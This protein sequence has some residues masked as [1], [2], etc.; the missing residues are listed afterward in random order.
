MTER[1]SFDEH[2]IFRYF[3]QINDVPRGSNHEAQ[4]SDMLYNLAL[5]KGY[6]TQRDHQG[7]ILITRPAAPGFEQAP[8]IIIQGHMDM[9]CEKDPDSDHDFL[10]DP[11]EMVEKNRWI[12]ANKTTLGA[13]DGI[14][15]A[16][17]FALLEEPDPM[18]QL[19]VLIT[20]TEETG[21]D[22]AMA[23]TPEYLDGDMLINIDSE[24]E[25]FVTVGCA[26]GATG[27]VHLPIERET[28]SAEDLRS[29]KLVISGMRGGHSGMEIAEVSKS[30][31]KLMTDY[32]RKINVSVSIKLHSFRSGSKHNA[33]PNHAEAIIS[34]SA[35]DALKVLDAVKAL[36]ESVRS[37]LLKLEPSISLTY[38]SVDVQTSV[39]TDSS[40]MRLL[41]CLELMPHG[42]YRMNPDG[43]SVETSDN[44]AVVDLGERSA[45]MV[46][47]VRSSNTARLAELQNKIGDV[48]AMF[49]G[50]SEFKDGYPAW[51]YRETSELRRLFESTFR[52]MYGKDVEVLIIHAGL[53][54]GLFAKKNPKLDMISFGP[55]ILGAHTSKERLSIDSTYRSY[56]LLKALIRRIGKLRVN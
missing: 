24:E 12:H 41:N 37:S 20:T 9:V 43:Q 53:E 48:A 21:M 16:M 44:L 6:D 26:G 1:F 52:D 11:I 32:L 23:V 14:G 45:E 54:C 34:Y 40:M 7:N 4:I 8:R 25:G 49:E 22:G 38:E 10:K 39:L 56:D 36:C 33:I 30:A 15:V 27:Y 42:V 46:L 31:L 51:E 29:M 17:G 35:C 18:P 13:D 55:D 3:R 50:T 47:S 2:A 5:S 19:Q 28:V